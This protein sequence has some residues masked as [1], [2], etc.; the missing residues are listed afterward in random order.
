MEHSDKIIESALRTITKESQALEG[1]KGQ[2]GDEF[3]NAID[4]IYRSKGRVIVTGIGKSANIANKIVA[5]LNSTGTPAIFMHA[6]DALHGDL[7]IVQKDDVVLALSHSGNTPEIKALLP[8]IKSMGNVLVGL[9]AR[10]DSYLGKQAN[11][12]LNTAVEEEACPNNLAPTSSTTAQLV[13]GDAVAVALL[14]LRNFSS[15]D[16][17]RY[18]PGGSLG[19]RLYVRVADLYTQNER[20]YV[21][22]DASVKEVIVEISTKRLGIT[23]VL[24]GSEMIG[25]VTDGDLR[26]MMERE[27]DVL[28]VKARDIMTPS[29]QYAEP[30]TLASEALHH[31]EDKNITQLVV[32]E[33]GEYKGI[34]HLH[35]ILKEGII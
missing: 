34:I 13:M 32:V 31:M 22:A 18:H 25:V 30:R 5:T 24:E 16:F 8:L 4:T 28:Q 20:P 6:A 3:A 27:D 23:A 10:S 1:L 15:E 26:R 29:P 17:A 35:D 19:K 14:E 11:F 12:V 7:G 33:E 2:I 9:T 21:Q